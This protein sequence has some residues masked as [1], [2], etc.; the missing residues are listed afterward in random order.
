MSDSNSR[1]SQ[2][3]VDESVQ[4]SCGFV[5]TAFV[6]ASGRF[7][8]A[9][10]NALRQAGLTPYKD[11]FKSSA[12]MDTN[13]RMRAARERLLGLAGSK[14]RVAVFFGPYQRREL[15]KHSLQALQ[16]TLVRNGIRPSRLNV[17]FDRDIFASP[18]EA[19]RIHGLFHFLSSAHI[20]P[21]EDSR[22]RLGIQVADA[23]AHS[24]GQIL[25][26]ELTGTPK[27]VEASG[28]STGYAPGTR[29]R[30]GW[31]LLMTLRH[32]LLTRP[33]VADGGRYAVG[34][35]PV[36]LD[37]IHDDPVNYASHPILLGWGVQIAPEADDGEFPASM[38]D[39]RG[40][41][42]LS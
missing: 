12:R 5:V 31:H 36:V 18:P 22:Q 13:P 16:S 38:R 10:E 21:R 35:D 30:L 11:E 7:D 26:E 8:R 27:N 19:V 1:P 3:F 6:F 24:F 37:P 39:G 34:P 4:S 41:A 29:S 14:A 15:G 25:K 20:H 32:S 33:M 28:P 2:C 40:P 17:Y 23:V 9:V 42:L